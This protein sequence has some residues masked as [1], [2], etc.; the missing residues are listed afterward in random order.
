MKSKY[1]LTLST[2]YVPNWNYVDAVRELFQNALDNET[3]S[4]DNKMGFEYSDNILRITNK[5]SKLTLDSLLLGSTTKKDDER[6]I[7]QHGEG[8]KIAFMVLLREG[9]KVTVLNYGANEI[10]TT[11]LVKSKRY[12]GSNVVQIEVDKNPIWKKAPNSD[13]T[14]LVD[15]LSTEEYENIVKSNLHLRTDVKM[16]CLAGDGQVLLDESERG[17][18]YVRG[19]YV[20][21]DKEIKYGYN[22]T[23]NG[24]KL[25]RDRKLVDSFNIRWHASNIWSNLGEEYSA[26]VANMIL[27]NERDVSFINNFLFGNRYN[28]ASNV[29]NKLKAEHGEN[30]YPVVD[31]TEYKLAEKCGYTPHIVSALVGNVVSKGEVLEELDES[32]DD[33]LCSMLDEFEDMIRDLDLSE[34]AW[35]LFERIKDKADKL[36]V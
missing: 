2:G 13:L 21:N 31:D 17:N 6:Q 36:G 19:L 34:E 5:T 18:I 20:C 25:D 10:W 7:G 14:V 4:P 11:K 12:N 29:L 24:I 8:Y 23:T 27:D 33:S 26:E 9:K 32:K 22:F 3:I 35:E 28:I 30:V 15:G 16:T 1:E